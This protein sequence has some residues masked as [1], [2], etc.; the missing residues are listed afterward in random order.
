MKRVESA[1]N[2]WSSNWK[3]RS[4]SSSFYTSANAW[5]AGYELEFSHLIIVDIYT[6]IICKI[7]ASCFL[8]HEHIRITNVQCN[9]RRNCLSTNQTQ[10]RN[11]S[12]AVFYIVLMRFLLR[13][14]NKCHKL[15]QNALAAI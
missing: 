11:Q 8:E 9:D 7:C 15:Q 6:G 14:E 5:Q 4:S 1:I 3:E 13:L 2:C 10:M 12:Q